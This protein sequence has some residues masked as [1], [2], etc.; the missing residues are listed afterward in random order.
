MYWVYILYSPTVKKFSTSNLQKRIHY[1]N[2]NRSPYTKHKGP[3]RLVYTEQYG[4]KQEALMRER[5]L[6]SWKSSKR[7]MEELGIAIYP[8]GSSVPV[9]TG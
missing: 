1:H 6:K 8:I 7:I 4:V 2:N 5:E 3:W 9:E